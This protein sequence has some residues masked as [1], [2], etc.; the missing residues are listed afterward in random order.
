MSPLQRLA[1][2][3]EAAYCLLNALDTR[4]P[5]YQ[6]RSRTEI[7]QAVHQLIDAIDDS[8]G[9]P[10][11]GYFAILRDPDPANDADHPGGSAA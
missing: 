5:A 1:N 11:R 4:Q 7:V 2:A 6:A 3:R 9:D 10:L 8:S